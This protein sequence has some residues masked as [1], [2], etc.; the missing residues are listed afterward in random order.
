MPRGTCASDSMPVL[1][2]WVRLVILVLPQITTTVTLIS[3]ITMDGTAELDTKTLYLWSYDKPC[4]K[5]NIYYS[6]SSLLVFKCTCQLMANV[7]SNVRKKNLNGLFLK[8]W[9]TNRLWPRHLWLVVLLH[10]SPCRPAVHLSLPFQPYHGVEG[11]C[12]FIEYKTKRLDEE[13][14]ILFSTRFVIA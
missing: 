9:H 3:H 7:L 2:R 13:L 14:Y 5:Y 12:I 1:Q 8:S 11:Y 10:A 4:T 6:W